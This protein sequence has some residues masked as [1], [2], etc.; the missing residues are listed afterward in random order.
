VHEDIKSSAHQTGSNIPPR[1]IHTALFLIA[2]IEFPRFNETKNKR[3]QTPSFYVMPTRSPRRGLADK[4]MQRNKK[5]TEW[6]N[7][8]R[9]R[10]SIMDSLSPSV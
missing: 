10:P 1:G 5:K 6:Q 8:N 4:D 7:K 3:Q 9:K 2:L